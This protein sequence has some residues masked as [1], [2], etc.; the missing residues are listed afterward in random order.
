MSLSNNKDNNTTGKSLVSQEEH[1]ADDEDN[2]YALMEK[3][4]WNKIKGKHANAKKKTWP[5]T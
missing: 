2:I 3:K 1:G 4:V 5:P